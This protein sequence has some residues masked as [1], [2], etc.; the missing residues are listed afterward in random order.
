MP[1]VEH[2]DL[3]EYDDGCNIAW[4]NMTKALMNVSDYLF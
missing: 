1:K 3:N 4:L 2:R